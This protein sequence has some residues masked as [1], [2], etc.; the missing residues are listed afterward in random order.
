MSFECRCTDVPFFSMS[1]ASY[2]RHTWQGL[3]TK[4]RAKP[5][6]DIEICR[7]WFALMPHRPEM[8]ISTLVWV[9]VVREIVGSSRRTW[10]PETTVGIQLSNHVSKN[11]FCKPIIIDYISSRIFLRIFIPGYS[12]KR[13]IVSAPESYTGMIRKSLYLCGDLGFHIG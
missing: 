2:C 4:F 12:A 11:A 6:L 5:G 1:E 13:L 9:P 8:H 7:E 3:K 10:R